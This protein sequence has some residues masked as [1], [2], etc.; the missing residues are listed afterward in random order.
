MALTDNRHIFKSLFYSSLIMRQ[1]RDD[2]FVPP[3][4]VTKLILS[5]VVLMVNGLPDP[6]ACT[7]DLIPVVTSPF[8]S[9]VAA[10]LFAFS[11]FCKRNNF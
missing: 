11:I 4:T 3:W 8:E 1:K 6:N 2:K 9:N 7:W 5:P 10:K